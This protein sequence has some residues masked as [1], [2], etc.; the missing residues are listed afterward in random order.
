MNT[1]LI[2]IAHYEATAVP[3]AIVTENEARLIASQHMASLNPDED[4]C[5]HYYAVYGRN[6]KGFF[7]HE[8]EQ[9]N[10]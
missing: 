5:P 4:L 9:F 1:D 3:V 10:P 7:T 2:L 6:E 8:I